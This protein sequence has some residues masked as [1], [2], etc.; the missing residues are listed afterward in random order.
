M[1]EIGNWEDGDLTE[2]AYVTLLSSKRRGVD[3][4]ERG[5][6]HSD[7]SGVW[8]NIRRISIQF[9]S[10]QK[11]DIPRELGRRGVGMDGVELIIEYGKDIEYEA[12][13]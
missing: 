8:H 13:S 7:A 6:S 1:L 11:V 2:N 9:T 5:S 12:D 10:G 3:H 4:E